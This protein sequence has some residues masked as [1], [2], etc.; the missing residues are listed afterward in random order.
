MPKYTPYEDELI[1][2]KPC[3]YCG[4]SFTPFHESEEFCSVICEMSYDDYVE[5][6]QYFCEQDM[7][8][9]VGII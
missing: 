9:R 6:Y 1:Q 4:K 2:D 3:T 8:R 7:L 5:D